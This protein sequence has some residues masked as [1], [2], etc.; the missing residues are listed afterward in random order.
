MPN[1]K[2]SKFKSIPK[3]KRRNSRFQPWLRS[4]LKGLSYKILNF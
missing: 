4:T 2:A 1:D 3:F